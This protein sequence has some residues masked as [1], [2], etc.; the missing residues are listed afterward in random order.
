[1]AIV[2]GH[3]G[4]GT[5]RSGTL[6][7]IRTMCL[8]HGSMLIDVDGDTLDA[9]M[10][11]KEGVIRDHFQIV[12]RGKVTPKLVAEPWQHPDLRVSGSQGTPR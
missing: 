5:G 9:R 3:G 12:K 10:L 2:T 7:I 11:N 6:P 4:A 8:E 1:M